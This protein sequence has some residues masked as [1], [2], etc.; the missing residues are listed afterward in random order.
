MAR[1]PAPGR[2]A[3]KRWP[4]RMLGDVIEFVG[5]SQ[6]PKD[7]FISEPREG[8]VRLVQIRD[9]KTDKYKTYIPTA[10]AKRAFQKDDVMIARYG[11][12]VFQILRGLEG[13]YNVALMKAAPT[14]HTTKEE[15]I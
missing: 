3:A 8:Y 6:P 7:T 15:M 10:L 13:S 4:V 11:P 1:S 14:E 2:G 9:F 12:P 5:G